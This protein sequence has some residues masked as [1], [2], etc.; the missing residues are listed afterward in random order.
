[1]RVTL[2]GA[3]VDL[4]RKD[5]VLDAVLATLREQERSPLY[6]ASAN[7]DH[8]HHFGLDSGLEGTFDSG[9]GGAEWLVLLDGMPLVWAANRLTGRPWEQLAGSDLLPDLL[10]TAGRARA[11]VGFL[12]G[13]PQQHR[14]LA[15]TVAERYSSV[16]IAGLW[17]PPR[18]TIDDPEASAALAGEIADAD[19][20]LLVVGLGKPRQELWLLRHGAKTGARAA[21]AF[22]AAADFLAGTAI[23][24]PERLRRSGLEWLHRLAHEPRR[25][26]R[27]YLLQGPASAIRL[28]TQSQGAVSASN[29]E[30]EATPPVF[31]TPGTWRR[32]LGRVLAVSDAVTIGLASAGAYLARDALGE[33][34]LVRGF[35]NE[36]PTALAVLPLWLLVLHLSGAYRPQYLN[37]GGDAF[38]R[39][40]S[41]ASVG[42]L[43]LGFV[44]F[45]LNLSL[46]R[47]YVG[48]LFA[49]VL[50]LGSATRLAVR[51]DLR[52]RRV[53]GRF[54]QNVVIAGADEEAVETAQALQRDDHGGYRA[55]GFVAEDLPVGSVVVEGLSVLGRPEEILDVA[56]DTRAGLVLASP[57]GLRPGT[58]RELTTS[59]EGSPVDFAVAPS[60]FQVVSRRVTVE[61]VA[62]VP[63]LHVDQVRLERGKA[64]LKR[65]FD[66]AVAVLLLMGTMPVL[67]V[68]AALVRFGDGG[69]ALFRQVRVGRGG[70][71]FEIVK[72]RTM[73]VDA[74]ERLADIEHLNEAGHAFFKVREDPRVTRVGRF[75]RKWSIDELPQLWNVLR[76]DMSLVGPR[77]PLPNEVEKYEAWQLRRL[78]VRPGITGVWQTS[79]RSEVPFDEAVRLDLFYIENWSLGFDL[80]LLGKTVLA[81]LGR[82]GAY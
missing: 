10:L 80:F 18:S 31:T 33:A 54:Q 63:I 14:L 42:T 4:L 12:G 19:V 78:R 38:R 56:Y 37:T 69:P 40:V 2:G 21:V 1:M 48:L 5:E 44:S 66:L 77:P 24:A 39:F 71:E 73:V 36:L 55:V 27:R 74:E 28:L 59:L 6:I 11:R 3:E 7:L 35:A 75:L 62:N 30:S 47:L 57:S 20:D 9:R 49:F 41:G 45:A 16:E 26:A 65:T 68:A 34:G 22:G 82:R 61:S 58:L 43:T 79:G 52:R 76:G 72:L 15:T 60:L 32:R 64:F 29:G 25:L 51:A 70:R 13:T 8:L 81:V 67:V 23:R 46:S 50:V 17:A 53:R